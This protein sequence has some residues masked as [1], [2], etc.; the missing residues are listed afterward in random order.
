MLDAFGL[1]FFRKNY[2]DEFWALRNINLEMPK[3]RRIGLIGNNGA[4]KSTLLKM[5]IGNITPTEG[6][7]EVNGKIQ[8]LMELGTAFHPEFTGREN[9]YASLS[10]QGLSTAEI[11]DKEEEIIDFAEL[12]DFINQPIRT[13]S[14]GMNARLSFSVATSISP[15]ILIIDEILGAGDAYFAGKC[16]ER[17]KR[18]T[19]DS[20]ATVIFVSH[21]LNSVLQLCDEV[22]WV[23]R[24]RFRLS[25]DPLYVVKEY[26]AEVRRRENLRLQM[27]K[28][29][30]GLATE[31]PLFAEKQLFRLM[32]K[33]QSE[34]MGKNR[35]YSISLKENSRISFVI[36]LGT[37]MDNDETQDAFIVTKQGQTNWSL[38][39]G[40][41]TKP[42]R[43]LQPSHNPDITAPFQF[44][45]SLNGQTTQ[46]TL[47]FDCD[48]QNEIWVQAYR[49]NAYKTI[50]VLQPSTNGQQVFYF[51]KDYN[52]VASEE[53]KKEMDKPESPDL[54]FPSAGRSA[55]SMESAER[56]QYGN[57]KIVI[58]KVSLTD[59]GGQETRVF[60]LNS[61]MKV[62]IEY[63]AIEKIPAPVFIFCIYL[64]DGRCASQW[65]ARGD[66]YHQT[67]LIG[68][69]QVVF[70]VNKLL[71][72]KGSYV[73]SIGIFTD[74]PRGGVEAES[75]HVI[76]RS[77]FF[78]IAQI[79]GDDVEKG[80][81]MQDYSIQCV[82]EA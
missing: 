47:A 28:E 65:F 19:D 62:S 26:N 52:A 76:D 64:A 73:C 56:Y 54:P 53:N 39:D 20:A 42:F 34:E 15:D 66:D 14:A 79:P 75:Y 61:P 60:E 25:G 74:V 50:G 78:D 32:Q 10:Y 6:K 48:I 58:E 81:C 29:R 55:D 67:S 51:D 12:G 16:V 31:V 21:D 71:L 43:T 38:P 2:Y 35:F 7:V 46:M 77:I 1:R 40:S 80:L 82:M 5:I 18:I 4:G 68:R 63:N 72:G 30:A 33:N 57:R 13:Y 59:A 23:D 44:P 69:G 36:E 17:M 11:K 24:G 9:I 22:I 3:G 37:P 8:A 70:Q 27:K 41:G 49:E 45:G